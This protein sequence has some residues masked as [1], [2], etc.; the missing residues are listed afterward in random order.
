MT[1][2]KDKDTMMTFLHNLCTELLLAEVVTKNSVDMIGDV[3]VIA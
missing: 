1:V 2:W 3:T